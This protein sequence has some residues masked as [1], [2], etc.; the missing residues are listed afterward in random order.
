[1]FLW[2]LDR[3]GSYTVVDPQMRAILK[4]YVRHICILI[5]LYHFYGCSHKRQINPGTP[6]KILENF[7]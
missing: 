4:E 7:H 6:Q 2:Q 1:M 3:V 5:L